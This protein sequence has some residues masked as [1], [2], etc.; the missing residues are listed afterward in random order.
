MNETTSR[1]G[2]KEILTESLA[3]KICKM[4]EQ[5]PDSGILVTWQNVVIHTE[6]RFGHR[7]SRQ[8]LSQKE[9]ND[10][11]LIGDAFNEAKTVQQRLKQDS[12]PKYSTAAR[13]VLQKRIAA[14]EAKVLTLQ[15]ELEAERARQVHELDIF[16]NTRLDLRELIKETALQSPPS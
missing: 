9:W 7:F 16:L 6:K 10:R 5:F 11:K 1:L 2:R 15:E 8:M 3:R 14:L 13:A 4:I 12:T